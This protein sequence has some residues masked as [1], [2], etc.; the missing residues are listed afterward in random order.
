MNATAL[1]AAVF[2]AC[3]VEAVEATTIVVAAGS[4]RNWRS[5]LL[6]AGTAAVVL[7]AVVAVFGPAILLLP[8]AVLRVVIGGLLLVFGLQ[9]LRKA[10]LRASGVKALHD[11]DAIFQKQVAA[12]RAAGQ[13]GRFGVPDWYAFT[14]SFKG[15]LLEGLEVVFIVLTFATNQ[16]D[17]PVAVYAALAAV[18][19]VVIAGAAVRGP[20]SRVPENTLKFVVGVMLS[21]FG[22]FWGA[23]GVG[24]LWPGSDAAL[25]VIAPAIAVYCLALAGTYRRRSR[26]IAA[27]GLPATPPSSAAFASGGSAPAAPARRRSWYASFGLFWYDFIIGDDWQIAAGVALTLVVV[28]VAHVWPLAWVFAAVGLLALIPYGTWR[29]ARA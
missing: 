26:T 27:K 28:A 1:F 21:A 12:A 15:V 3:L 14:L 19:I 4:T 10:V 16:G 17:L 29:A 7:V 22:V 24:A 11:E 2:L 18:V 25:L 20:L 13:G 23:E 6:G 8:L 9:W 5:A